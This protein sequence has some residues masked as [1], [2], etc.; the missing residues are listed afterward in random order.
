MKAELLGEATYKIT[1]DKTESAAVPTDGKSFEMQRFICGII[2]RLTIEQGLVFP[3]GRLLV[4]AFLRS[5]G[6]SVFFVSAL[7]CEM[8]CNEHRYYSCEISGVERLRFL[9]AALSAAGICCCIYCG[10]DPVR[11]RFIFTDPPSETERICSE[12]GEYCEISS[13]F[14][15]QSEE[16]LTE[17]A[18]GNAPEMLSAIL[19]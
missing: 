9:C 14:A 17:I 16:Y 12:F 15:A 2:D 3:D 10:N 7:E 6:S 18:S 13:L 11:Y 19:G 8:N 5:D 1:L 4:E